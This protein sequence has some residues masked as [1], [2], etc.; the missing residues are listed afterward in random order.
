VI[1][2]KVIAVIGSSVVELPDDQQQLP[3]HVGKWIAEAQ[4]HLLTGGGP[5]V[6]ATAGKGFCSV[7]SRVGLSIGVIPDGKLAGTYPNAWIELP[8]YTHL[9]GENPKGS[10]SRNHINIRTSH[11]IVAFLGGTGT[12]AEVE[13]AVAWGASCPIVACL[14]EQEMIGGL[15]AEA[16]RNLG[17]PVVGD[18]D[19]IIEF[20]NTA[21]EGMRR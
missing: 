10:D 18:L 3:Y 16:L 7:S 19:G 17:V 20:L 9:K 11:A 13:L 2:R 12:R 8:I 1:Q 14:G 15:G 21:L 5:G 6:M 4:C